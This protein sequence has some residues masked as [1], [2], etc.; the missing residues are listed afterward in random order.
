RQR[1]P[2]YI[3]TFNIFNFTLAVIAAWWASRLVTNHL[4]HNNADWALGAGAA[5]IVYVLVNNA[6]FATILFLARGHS[7]RAILVPQVIAADA[8]LAS[9]GI[10]FASFW[11]DDVWLIPF[12]IA[13]V[14]LLHQALHLPQLQE[15]ARL[16]PKTELFHARHFA[17][18]L[19]EELARARQFGRP[20]SVVLGDLDLLRNINGTY[21]HLAGDAVLRGVADVIRSH[22]RE[23]DI[24]ARLGG[25]EFAIMLPE[26]SRNGA[27]EIA[28]RIREAVANTP[29]WAA[30]V[31]E[32]VT[33]TLSI[34]VAA[35][36]EDGT[37]ATDLAHGA[38]LAAYR[39]KPHGRNRVVAASQEPFLVP[40]VRLVAAEALEQVQPLPRPR[41]RLA[42]PARGGGRLRDRSVR[43]RRHLRADRTR[44]ACRLRVLLGR[45]DYLPT[46]R[47]RRGQR[48]VV[49]QLVVAVRLDPSALRRLRLR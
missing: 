16:D 26:T 11:R 30:S 47:R 31:E 12:A 36:P 6:G 41:R 28:R 13:P 45:G 17:E 35:F 48:A 27:M 40:V 29:F 9:L 42:R 14:F 7:P 43:H 1:Y 8:A 37:Q 39:A 19:E 23:Y 24:G 15:E 44:R 49:A 25:E 22:A 46:R 20:L 5:A 4:I 21:G 32:H 34:G 3:Q 2:W 33:A 10:A 18:A 38:D